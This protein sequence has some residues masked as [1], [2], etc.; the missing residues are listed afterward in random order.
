MPRPSTE[1]LVVVDFEL[2]MMHVFL[3]VLFIFLSFQLKGLR[4]ESYGTGTQVRYVA[5]VPD[6]RDI[7]TGRAH[8]HYRE[9]EYLQVLVHLL[10]TLIL[11][12]TLLLG[13]FLCSV[14]LPGRSAM[15]ECSH[16]RWTFHLTTSK[17]INHQRITS[18]GLW[19]HFCCRFSLFDIVFPGAV[20]N[21]AHP[22]PPPGVSSLLSFC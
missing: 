14:S 6:G 3:P 9:R 1:N 2:T 8:Y 22:R 20:Q 13:S 5:Y 17:H 16:T 12:C 18:V 10:L 4:V 7:W 11:C 15:G 19:S 21:V